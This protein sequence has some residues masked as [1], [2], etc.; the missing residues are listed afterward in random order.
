MNSIPRADLLK[1]KLTD[2]DYRE[3][4]MIATPREIKDEFGDRTP[5]ERTIY[6]RLRT[7]NLSGIRAHE[8]KLL[9]RLLDKSGGVVPIRDLK[10]Q[11]EEEKF[12]QREAKF[13]E[14]WNKIND[15]EKSF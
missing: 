4:W 5:S 15:Y 14:L 12:I 10:A 3:L 9:S 13:I 8:K 2:K 1:Y 6:R 11:L 7:Y